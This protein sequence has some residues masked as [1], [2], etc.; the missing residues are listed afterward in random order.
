MEKLDPIPV[1]AA[2]ILFAPH[3]G[4]DS[5]RVPGT[6]L[7]KINPKLIIIGEAPAEHLHYYPGYDTITQNSAGD[8]TLDC[9]AGKTHIYVSDRDYSVDFLADD[10]KP[11]DYGGYY[12]GT[13]TT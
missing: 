1:R 11:D 10:Q 7:E 2:D 6:W 9:E 12:I 3:H 5:G 4:R 13:L 8:I